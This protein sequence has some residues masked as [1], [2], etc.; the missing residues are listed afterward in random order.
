[1]ITKNMG[2]VYNSAKGKISEAKEKQAG[3]RTVTAE[4]FAE[5]DS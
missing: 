5:T 2:E 3:R 1:M 4:I